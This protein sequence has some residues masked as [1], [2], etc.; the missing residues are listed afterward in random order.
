VS[1]GALG[2]ILA[3]DADQNLGTNLT[4]LFHKGWRRD[5]RLSGGI[6]VEKCCHDLDILNW[7]MDAH[8]DLAFSRSRRTHFIPHPSAGRHARFEVDEQRRSED[9]DFGDREINEAF[10]TPSPA[11]AFLRPIVDTDHQL[12]NDRHKAP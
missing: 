10:Y 11:T 1:S 12:L 2:S 3:I 9:V 5:N 4:N 6:M 7:L 8:V